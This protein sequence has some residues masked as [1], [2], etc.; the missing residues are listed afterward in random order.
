MKLYF[1]RHGQTDWNIEGKIQGSND[2]E[3]NDIGINQAVELGN[4]VLDSNIKFS[5]IYSSKLKRAL[6]TAEILSTYTNVDYTQIEGFEEINFG[7]WEGLSLKEARDKYPNEY[8]EWYHNRRYSKSHNGESYQE[9]IERVLE[10]LHIIIAAD[11]DDIAIV[12]HSAVIMGLQCLITDTPFNDMKK[13]KT[14]NV[15]ITEID[16]SKLKYIGGI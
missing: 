6:K 7:Y 9:M 1:I 11:N 3:L 2:T 14:D 12:T 16:S 15:G 13:F 5:K 8:D 10:A 4:K